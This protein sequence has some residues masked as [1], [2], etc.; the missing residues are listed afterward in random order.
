MWDQEIAWGES[1]FQFNFLLHPRGVAK[2]L[3]SLAYS[4][5]R[6]ILALIMFSFDM[7]IS[8]DCHDWIQQKNFL[9]WQKRP[10]KVYLKPVPRDSP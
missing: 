1:K 10:L 4:E 7:V 9:M 8:E 6:L 3:Y 5:M 2:P